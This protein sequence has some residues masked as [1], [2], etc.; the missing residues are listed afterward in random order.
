MSDRD[1]ETEI[2]ALKDQVR[3]LREI[4]RLT[5]EK[6]DTRTRQLAKSVK[7]HVHAGYY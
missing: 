5:E 6:F 1:M 4:L 2:D 7:N 3:D